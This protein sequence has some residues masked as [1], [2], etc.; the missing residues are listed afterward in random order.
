M[1]KLDKDKI[2]VLK[3]TASLTV[4]QATNYLLPLVTLPYLSRVLG[5]DKFGLV[6]FAQMFINYFMILTDYGFNQIGVRQIAQNNTNNR[7][8]SL[9]VSSIFNLRAFLSIIG[10]GILLVIVYTFDKFSGN[11]LL[12]LL[13]YGMVVGNMMMPTWFFQ[14][15]QQMKYITLLN[16]ISKL[17]F[18][19][20]I[21][22]FVH[23]KEDYVLVPLLN[24]LGF[25]FSGIIAISLL[26]KK[27]NISFYIAPIKIIKKQIQIGFSMF[28]TNLSITSYTSTNAFILGNVVSNQSMGYYGGV[29]K[30][31]QTMKFMF[32]PVYNALYPYFSNSYINTPEKF[33]KEIK[34]GLIFSFLG[35]IFIFSS[36]VFFAED[37]ISLILGE[38][39]L[40]GLNVFYIFSVLILITPISYFL[41]NVIFLS[42]SLERYSMRIYVI[43]GVFNIFLLIILLYF[44]DY[45]SISAAAAN[46]LTQILNL[47]IALWFISKHIRKVNSKK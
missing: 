2:T 10:F 45:P 24:S 6:F 29:E 9:I 26:I 15:I 47:T 17:I 12:F 21:F 8:L 14:G 22:V 23:S 41:F 32:T 35:G 4:L 3:N 19:I 36:I 39:Y 40:S 20:S 7:K 1:T 38:E 18:T 46:V 43:G 33:Y 5:P 16:L 28:A 34:L 13:T 37:I 31:I 25:I 11:R 42:L 30:I 44:F 27:Y